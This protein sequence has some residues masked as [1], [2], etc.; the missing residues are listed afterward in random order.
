MQT[1]HHFVSRVPRLTV[2]AALIALCS[3]FVGC[4][5]EPFDGQVVDQNESIHF[6]GYGPDPDSWIAIQVEMPF[7]GQYTPW[8]TVAWARTAQERSELFQSAPPQNYFYQYNGY[9]TLP[10]ASLKLITKDGRRI[11]GA[12]VRA[13]DDK[14]STSYL[15]VRKDRIECYGNHLANASD[16]QKACTSSAPVT[17]EI[18]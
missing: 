13:Y 15:T 8:E 2:T 5:F 7:N 10:K 16:Y 18:R 9:F 11:L 6:N 14:R 1:T 17:L 12:R 3:T 4:L